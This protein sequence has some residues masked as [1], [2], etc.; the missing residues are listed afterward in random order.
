MTTV[1]C[2]EY[3]LFL[4]LSQTQSHVTVNHVTAKSA[5]FCRATCNA[6]FT[7]LPNPPFSAGQSDKSEV[8][9]LKICIVIA[10]PRF[11]RSVVKT[12]THCVPCS[13]QGN[14]LIS[15]FSQRE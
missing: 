12:F 6:C 2:Q 4:L 13:F 5:F 9:N 3:F 11:F 14:M 10:L 7:L 8:S 15:Q 1:E